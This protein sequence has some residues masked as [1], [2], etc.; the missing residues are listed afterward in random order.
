MHDL[1]QLELQGFREVVS[2]ILGLSGTSRSSSKG[3][4]QAAVMARTRDVHMLRQVPPAG[5]C[6]CH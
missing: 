2:N 6:V 3:L 4:G 1:W 5:V